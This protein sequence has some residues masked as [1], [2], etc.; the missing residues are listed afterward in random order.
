MCSAVWSC[1][2]PTTG[3]PPVPVPPTAFSDQ[4]LNPEAQLCFSPHTQDTAQEREEGA[5]LKQTSIIFSLTPTLFLA[6]SLT[7][8]PSLY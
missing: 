8:L 4:S 1:N 3:S 2:I 7:S 5:V 6:Y